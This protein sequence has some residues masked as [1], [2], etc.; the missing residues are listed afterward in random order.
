MVF[1]AAT[2]GGHRMTYELFYWPD[3]QGRGEFVRLALEEAAAPYLD[4]ARTRGG[5]K[6]MTAMMDDASAARPPFAP[7]FLKAGSMVIAQ[8]AN[9][10]M[11]LGERHRLA[12][13][14]DAGRL[15]TYQLQLTIADVVAEV[16]DA[17]HPIASSLYYEDQKPEARRRAADLV[18]RRL[19]KYLGYFERVLANNGR[20]AWLAGGRVSYADLSLFQLVEGLQYAFPKAM[21]RLARRHGRVMRVRDAVAARPRIAAYLQSPRRIPFNEQGIFR[22]YPELDK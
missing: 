9:I 8:T 1:A 2:R 5:M 7:P 6:R 18:A 4:V 19:P 10:L 22:H 16:H 21:K 15:F 12:P 3:I 17:H 11:F 13:R 20:G 14:D